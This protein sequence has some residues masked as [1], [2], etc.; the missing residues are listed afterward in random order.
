MRV[1]LT[2]LTD[3]DVLAVSLC[4]VITGEAQQQ[5]TAHALSPEGRRDAQRFPRQHHLA[6]VALPASS[7]PQTGCA[8][9]R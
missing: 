4:H 2:R 5:H 9:R 8:G 6:P 3:G 7:K 1:R